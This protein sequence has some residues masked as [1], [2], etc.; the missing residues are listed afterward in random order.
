MYENGYISLENSMQYQAADIF[1][2]TTSLSINPFAFNMYPN[3]TIITLNNMMR[4]WNW[5]PTNF[6]REF[7][8]HTIL[9]QNMEFYL[10]EVWKKTGILNW[11]SISSLFGVSNLSQDEKYDSNHLQYMVFFSESHFSYLFIK[12]ILVFTNI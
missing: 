12:Y 1:V 7:H 9:F 4:I 8:N 10:S 11:S 5:F 3:V 2:K 6:A